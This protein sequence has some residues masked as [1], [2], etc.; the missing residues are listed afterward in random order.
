VSCQ[1][2]HEKMRC[3]A[4]YFCWLLKRDKRQPISDYF[5]T[6]YFA[7][8]VSCCSLVELVGIGL[9][10][11]SPPSSQPQP[12]QPPPAP[13]PQPPAPRSSR[14]ALLCLSPLASLSLASRGQW[15]KDKSKRKRKSK[16]GSNANANANGQ[17]R[18]A[19]GQN[20]QPSGGGGL[21]APVCAAFL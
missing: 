16:Y 12:P 2:T 4:C 14:C 20:H 6:S 18:M 21:E 19:N 9:A 13:S 15:T 10:G 5:N 1:H 8:L 7:C 11:P 17:C 3:G